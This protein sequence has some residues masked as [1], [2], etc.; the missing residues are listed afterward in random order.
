MRVVLARFCIHKF[1][2]MRPMFL[3]KTPF[4]SAL[5]VYSNRKLFHL[6]FRSLLFT[7]SYGRIIFW[8]FCLNGSG[9]KS[10]NYPNICIFSLKI[11]FSCYFSENPSDSE[12]TEAVMK[13][14]FGNNY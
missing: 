2:K 3:V 8:K 7:L 10:Q 9:G 1:K 14:C 6:H 13:N 5:T 4:K 11:L 12:T